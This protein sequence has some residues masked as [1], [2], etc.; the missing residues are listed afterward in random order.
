MKLIR[1]DV[2]WYKY[3]LYLL[4]ACTFTTA[5]CMH[6]YIESPIVFIT[7]TYIHYHCSLYMQDYTKSP[8]VFITHITTALCTCRTILSLSVV[9]AVGNVLVSASAIP[10]QLQA[11]M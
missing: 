11:E 4:H 6:D 8:I 10:F 3:R 1:D 7:C 5:L 2:M 9:Y